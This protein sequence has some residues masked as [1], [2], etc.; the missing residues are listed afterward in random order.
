M[1]K[2]FSLEHFC[3]PLMEDPSYFSKKMFGGLSI[4]HMDLMRFVLAEDPGGREYRGETY[5]FD[6]W[7]GVLVCTS[8][9][10]HPSLQ[11]QWPNLRN[12]PILGKWL[13]LE[14][15]HP[16]FERTF[17]EMVDCT[18]AND[19]RIGIVPSQRSRKKQSKKKKVSKKKNK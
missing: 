8:R 7:N 4:Y 6:I 9:E 2:E 1:P 18:L 17:S 14:M 3:E 10:H 16:D 19:Q 15:A 13:Y 12:H 5:D 11:R